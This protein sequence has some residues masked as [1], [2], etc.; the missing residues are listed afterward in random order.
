[1][2]ARARKL[3][4]GLV[5]LGAIAAIFL[6]PVN[7]WALRL[8]ESIRGSGAIGV[9]LFAIAYV[10]ATVLLLPGSVLT[11][12]AGFAYGPLWGTLLVSP[13]SVLAATL[14]FLLGR[15][16]SRGWIARR[17]AG[18]PRFAVIDE[19]VGESGFRKRSGALR[20]GRGVSAG[21]R[22]SGPAAHGGSRAVAPPVE[23]RPDPRRPLAR[24]R[25]GSALPGAAHLLHGGRESL[26]RAVRARR[27]AGRAEGA[28]RRPALSRL[29]SDARALRLADVRS[30][31]VEFDA[32]AAVKS[33]SFL[34]SVP[35]PAAPQR[36]AVDLVRC[37]DHVGRVADQPREVR[38]GGM[39]RDRQSGSALPGCSPETGSLVAPLSMS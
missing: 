32:L 20:S 18:N 12:G 34:A 4:A 25:L 7:T 8:V 14:A 24:D 23:A 1:M 29:S 31:V 36:S 19:A 30:A 11:A 3:V 27:L 15:T 6:L 35:G 37:A 16:V 17:T 28:L 13:V 10:A 38:L 2:T 22:L 9:A 21:R 39:W 26:P 5:A 33:A